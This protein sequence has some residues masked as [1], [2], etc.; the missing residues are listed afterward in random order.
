MDASVKLPNSII[1]S[2]LHFVG[3]MDLCFL[4]EKLSEGK[5]K[6]QHCILQVPFSEA[7]MANFINKKDVRIFKYYHL[8]I[9]DLF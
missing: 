1:N 3:D 9:F 7:I 6:T 4:S 2:G 8:K 5:M